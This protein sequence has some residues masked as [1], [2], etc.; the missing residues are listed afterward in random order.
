MILLDF[1]RELFNYLPLN[2]GHMCGWFF[3]ILIVLFAGCK[4]DLNN[5]ANG[6]NTNGNVNGNTQQVI[7]LKAFSIIINNLTTTSASISW[8]SAADSSPEDSV[9]YSLYL[10]SNLIASKVKAL[11]YDFSNLKA[12]RRFDLLI[13]AF[14]TRND[15]ISSKTSFTT[16]DSYL[17]FAKRILPANSEISG[18]EITPDG[19][20]IYTYQG[21]LDSLFSNAD[22]TQYTRKFHV[23]KTDSLGNE[24]WNK[25]FN[26]PHT[27]IGFLIKATADGYLIL[28][29]NFMLKLD[30]TGN[31]VWKNI[32]N[33]DGSLALMS[34]IETRNRNI[35][36][37]GIQGLQTT[38]F[39]LLNLGLNGELRWQK[40]YTDNQRLYYPVDL[41]EV[42]TDNSVVV[43]G[44]VGINFGLWKSD[45]SGNFI[46]SK[47]F[48]ENL[49]TDLPTHIKYSNN[50]LVISGSSIVGNH[51]SQMKIYRVDLQGNVL[52]ENLLSSPHFFANINWLELTK[53]GGYA[54]LSFI[55]ETGGGTYNEIYKFDSNDKKQWENTYSE[56]MYARVLKQT[57]DSGY[58]LPPMSTASSEVFL[59]KTNQNGEY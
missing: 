26:F 17:K 12:N 29:S 30:F 46:S 31:L 53:D 54:V 20:Y 5:N 22:G 28:G 25:T 44:Q 35:I 1:K 19:G 4:K 38:A 47:A 52:Y 51:F 40:N 43:L 13:K 10:D 33:T 8:T 21:A 41:V 45:M 34:F 11:K 2:K 50:Q 49:A 7:K 59:I 39:T 14:T 58:I 57:S 56:F 6:N 3:L 36:I 55:I 23:A 15:S 24:L 48:G 27:S 9:T 32:L 42:P 37:A 18:F 16:K